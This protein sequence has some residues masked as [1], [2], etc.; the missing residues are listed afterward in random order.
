MKSSK[1]MSNSKKDKMMTF[2]SERAI[3]YK[4]KPEANTNDI[5]LREIEIDFVSNIIQK[6]QFKNILDFGC[7]NGFST[8]ELLKRNNKCHFEGWDINAD[9]IN[10]ANESIKRKMSTHISFKRIDLLTEKNKLKF[11]FIYTIRVFQNMENFEI[12]KKIFDKLYLKLNNGGKFLYIES[13]ASG[14]KEMNQDR[15]KLNLDLL[16]IHPHLTLLTSE[17]DK[18]VSSKMKSLKTAHL[19]SSYYLITRLLYSYLAKINQE[20]IDYNHPI[21]QIA[22][23]LPSIG[24]YGPQKAMLFQ[25]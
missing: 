16:P 20:K 8:L 25:K 1:S 13:Y 4:S 2:W 5:W 7:A 21:H 22:S 12:Q 15:L 10:V 23:K 18:Y 17:F 6:Y 19:S 11:D 24:K 9:M 3:E 14:Y